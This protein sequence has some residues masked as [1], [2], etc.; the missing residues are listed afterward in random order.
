[1]STSWFTS[2]KKRVIFAILHKLERKPR[3]DT[4]KAHVL[5]FRSQLWLYCLL[6]LFIYLFLSFVFYGRTHSMWRFPGLGSNQNW[7][8]QPTP[9]PQQCGI[10]FTSA[11]Y[12][13]VHG[14]AGSLTH[15]ARPGVKSASSWMPTAEPQWELLIVLF[16]VTWEKFFPSPNPSFLF[17]VM[18]TRGFHPA[19]WWY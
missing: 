9:Q 15:W 7:S 1:M 8:R 6:I 5:D 4:F 11:A 2:Y 16:N 19:A 17:R 14:N 18:W 13:T 3:S 12:S 10:W